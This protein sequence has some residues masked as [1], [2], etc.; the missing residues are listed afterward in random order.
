MEPWILTKS[1]EIAQKYKFRIDGVFLWST[2]SWDV[3]AVYPESTTADGSYFDPVVAEIIE[4][5]N[6]A[7]KAAGHEFMAPTRAAR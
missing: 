6:A 2:G 4:K 3:L 5:H 1:C 7:A